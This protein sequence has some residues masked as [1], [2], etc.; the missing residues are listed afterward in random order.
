MGLTS[1]REIIKTNHLF[2]WLWQKNEKIV[3]SLIKLGAH[4]NSKDLN[5]KTPL[6]CA[7]V[8]PNKLRIVT[9]LSERNI[10]AN[11]SLEE[12]RFNITLLRNLNRKDIN[13]IEEFVRSEAYLAEILASSNSL[14][15]Y[16]NQKASDFRFFQ[17]DFNLIANIKKLILEKNSD[18]W[19]AEDAAEIV[20]I[21]SVY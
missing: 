12:D 3:T 9:L 13:F 19:K 6:T 14:V 8:K 16:D 5:E 15:Y 20:P 17:E 10:D 4:I 1:T 21:Q 2:T 18:F 11:V 7:A